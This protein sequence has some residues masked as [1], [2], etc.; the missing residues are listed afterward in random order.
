MR[1]RR[2]KKP[3]IIKNKFKSTI[4]GTIGIY[5]GFGYILPLSY[6]SVYITSY[7]HIKQNFVNMHYG[8]FL[9]LILT[10]AM[11][12]S[13]S[14]GGLLENK[15]GYTFTTLLGTIIIFICNFFFFKIQNIWICYFLTLLLGIGAGITTSLLGKNLT[16]YHPNKKGIIVSLF[17][18]ALILI[19]GLFLVIGEKIISPD[20]ETLGDN[21]EVYKPETAERTYLYFML[22]F[23][24]I[25]IGDI[26]FLLFAHEYKKPAESDLNIP[27]E[28]IVNE[29]NINDNENKEEKKE[30][31]EK[32]I[33]EGKEEEGKPN[34]DIEEKDEK[35]I[36]K[37][38]EEEE[39]QNLEKNEEEKKEI[40]E[41]KKEEEIQNLEKNEEEKK[42]RDEVKEEEEKQNLE[43]NEEEKKEI[44]E[45]KEEEIKQNSEKKEEEIIEI[46]DGN[47]NEEKKPNLEKKEKDEKEKNEEKEGEEEVK[48]NP[49]IKE[50]EQIEISEGNNEEAK[51]NVEKKEEEQKIIVEGKEEEKLITEKKEEEQNN[52]NLD[53]EIE[54]LK[55]KKKIKQVIKTF[56][57]WKIALASFLL[58]FPISFM[59]TTGRTFG[60]LIGIKGAALQFLTMAQGAAIIIIGPIF[61]ILSDKKGP[62]LILRISSIVSILPGVLLLFFID[63]TVLYMI[64]FVFIA[65]GLVS[66]MVSFNPFLMEI[67]GI[68]ESVILGGIING[69]GKVGEVITVVAAFVISFKYSGN[70][71]KT[72]YK[73]I[74]IV[75]SAC[76][77]LSL[78]LLLFE[79]KKKFEYVD[80]MDTLDLLIDNDYITE[81]EQ[82]NGIN[83]NNT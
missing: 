42:E 4:L 24:T 75:G 46:N 61:G 6:L 2:C 57:F 52:D 31:D 43:K 40:D 77:L 51:Q 13:V 54:K 56:R 82:N 81:N 17:G 20:G 70:E 11:T 34:L 33:K 74:F 73:I 12:F 53:S 68:R 83:T 8:Y 80:D 28:E 23:F 71:I 37:G 30:Q 21:E 29:N 67:Y 55:R 78:I 65:I 62:L 7:I 35:E 38:K 60:A 72:P 14:L 32:E 47:E 64:S 58:S 18:M 5:F 59:M 25:P 10:F 9:N 15:L 50:K 63:N 76:S 16:L 45:V 79:S 22:G 1:C 36:N 19:A 44:D 41:V 39:K 48:Q 3:V 66:K 49:E 69:I 27:N 26:I